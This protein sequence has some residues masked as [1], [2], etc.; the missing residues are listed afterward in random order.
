[1]RLKPFSRNS[2]N[3]ARLL[4][5]LI[6]LAFLFGCSSEI[7]P[8]YK[9]KD[10]PFHIKKIC[11]EEYGLDVTTSVVGQTLWVYAPMPRII[12]KDYAITKEKVFDEAM[13]DKMRNIMTSIGRVLISSDRAPEFYSLVISDIEERG[14]DYIIIANVLDIKKSYASVLPWTEMNKRYVVKLKSA[15]EALGDTLGIHVIPYD[16]GLPEFIS[17]QIAQRIDSRLREPDFKNFYDVKAAEAQFTPTTLVI[18]IDIKLQ[19]LRL[20]APE[21]ND[22]TKEALKIAAQVTRAYDFEDFIEVQI[23]EGKEGKSTTFSRKVLETIRE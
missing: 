19:E 14:L 5:S 7:K 6:L 18:N 2:A 23:N 20:K 22:I 17:G 15:P 3:P 4:V 8:T 13:T 9:E 11:K 16:I 12:D 1:M 21:T 10:I